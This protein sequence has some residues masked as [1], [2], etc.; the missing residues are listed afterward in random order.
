[1]TRNLASL[2]LT[3][4]LMSSCAV[5]YNSRHYGAA[6][7]VGP[8]WWGT[9]TYVDPL[10]SRIDIDYVD[11]GGVHYTR[12]VYYTGATWDG[13]RYNDVRPGDRVWIRGHAD[14]DHW[15]AEHIRRY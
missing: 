13:V 14:R 10:A 4:L 12:P 5:G 3:L 8:E 11:G 1:M 2:S 6:V 15:R 7:A 9:V